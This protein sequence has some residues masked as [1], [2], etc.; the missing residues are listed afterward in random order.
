METCGFKLPLQR[1]GAEPALC[2]SRSI[3]DLRQLAVHSGWAVPNVQSFNCYAPSVGI[4][5]FKQFK[6]FDRFASFNHG[7]RCSNRFSRSNVQGKIRRGNFHVSGILEVEIE[8]AIMPSALC[9]LSVRTNFDPAF[10]GSSD[11]VEHN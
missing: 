4:R 9:P 10:H 11:P 3:D 2:G 1:S 7:D 6:P 5:P 8:R